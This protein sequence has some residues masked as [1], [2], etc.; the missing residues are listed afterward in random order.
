[1]NVADKY[2]IETLKDIK[3]NGQLDDNP[4]P[5]YEDGTLAYSKFITQV[6]HKYNVLNGEFPITTL[7]N[8]SIKSSFNE[9]KTIYIDQSN[10]DEDFKQVASLAI[11]DDQGRI[12]EEIT[13]PFSS[14]EVN[15]KV[16][17]IKT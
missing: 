1:M 11:F 8:G 6:V 15:V 7:R 16:S 14:V 2:F 17:K 9:L 5:K 10:K 4:R 13:P 3:K 12:I